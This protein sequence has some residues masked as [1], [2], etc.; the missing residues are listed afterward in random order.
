M[1]RERDWND[2]LRKYQE[3]TPERIRKKER[4]KERKAYNDSKSSIEDQKVAKVKKI[5][6]VK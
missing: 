2:N 1:Q 3:E 5:D 6:R 4:A